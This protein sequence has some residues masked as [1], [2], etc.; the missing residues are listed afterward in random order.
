[1]LRTLALLSLCLALVSS[2]RASAPRSMVDIPYIADGLD[3]HR[4]DLYLPASPTGA[5]VVI[6]VHGGAF[7]HGDRRGFA[8][9]GRDLANQGIAVVIPSY[10]LFPDSDAQGA[11]ND[12]AAAVA[13]TVT[14]AAIYGLDTTRLY[15]AGHSAGAQIVSM[16]GTHPRYLRKVGVDFSLVRGVVSLAGVYD[17]RNLSDEPQSWQV[18]D[19]KI[20]GQTSEARARISPALD[21]DPHAPP[22]M[23]VCGSEDDPDACVRAIY[24]MRRL[25]AARVS[26]FVIRDM[27]A[28]HMGVLR[29]AID[30]RDP[31]F[32]ALTHFIGLTTKGTP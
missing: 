6:F 1:M 19:F 13:W 7:M 14:H 2:A 12:V 15:L 30:P 22:F 9:V 10:R 3:K 26:A 25:H 18:V 31:V 29:S 21:I 24:F 16:L 17:V 5:P 4:L 28:N 32:T 8:A 27:G 20:Y 23:I 11:T